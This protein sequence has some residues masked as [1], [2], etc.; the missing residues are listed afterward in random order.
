[1]WQKLNRLDSYELEK[2]RV[3]LIN[4]IQLVSAVPCSYAKTDASQAL[5]KWNNESLCIESCDINA[6]NP[7]KISLDIQQLVL[8]I[9]GENNHIEHLV[10]SGITYPMAFGWMKIKLDSF[11]IDSDLFDDSND[12]SLERILGP[13]EELNV[14]NQH[15]FNELSI[16]YANAHYLLTQIKDNLEIEFDIYAEPAKLSLCLPLKSDSE[17]YILRF[18][19]GDKNFL[20]PYF[21]VQVPESGNDNLKNFIPPI[22]FWNN[23][24]WTGM[25]LL[26]GDFLSLD[27]EKEREKVYDFF[28]TNYEKIIDHIK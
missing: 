22:G 26:T 16:Y 28:K 2:A 20:E 21:A 23:K 18:T 25:V 11:E 7:L 15:V 4:A 14:T 19:P 12:Y 3:Q 5:L 24:D 13:N 10:L 17:D 8:S 6:Q 9:H 27:P 1:M